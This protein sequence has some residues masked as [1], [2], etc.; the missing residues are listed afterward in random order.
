MLS[1]KTIKRN[2]SPWHLRSQFF[3]KC[4]PRQ[5]NEQV[6]INTKSGLFNYS[7]LT[8]TDWVEQSRRTYSR[9]PQPS[10]FKPGFQVFLTPGECIIWVQRRI[11]TIFSHDLPATS[12]F[13]VLKGKLYSPILTSKTAAKE[14]LGKDDLYFSLKQNL[15]NRHQETITCIWTQCF[16]PKMIPGGEKGTCF[17]CRF[18]QH[19]LK[20][21]TSHYFDQ[22]KKKKI[23]ESQSETAPITSSSDTYRVTK[24]RGSENI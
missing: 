16:F 23:E 5:N 10:F 19:L 8:K 2:Y 22:K 17:I 20:E 24:T 13:V 9:S 18:F 21:C 12:H 7:V 4:Q 6:G 14:P 1:N 15:E 11:S 3:F